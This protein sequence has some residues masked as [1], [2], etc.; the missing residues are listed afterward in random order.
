MFAKTNRVE[1]SYNKDNGLNIEYFSDIE[2]SQSIGATSNKW[3][4]GAEGA[5]GRK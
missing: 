4:Y 3:L 5:I 1:S 2:R